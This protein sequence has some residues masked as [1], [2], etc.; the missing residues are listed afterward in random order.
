MLSLSRVLEQN[1]DQDF[2]IG[3]TVGTKGYTTNLI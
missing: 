2:K 1:Y 3:G